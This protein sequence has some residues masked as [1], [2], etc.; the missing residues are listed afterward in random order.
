MEQSRI[1]RINELSAIARTR[2]LTEEETAERTE[3]RQEFV[4]AIR[5]DLKNQLDNIEFVDE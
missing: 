1:N 5:M 3:L 2:E 4:A